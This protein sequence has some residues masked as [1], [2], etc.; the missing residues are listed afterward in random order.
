MKKLR[1]LPELF[2]VTLPERRGVC[3]RRFLMQR[4]VTGVGD[5]VVGIAAVAIDATPARWIIGVS[6]AVTKSYRLVD[7][8][9]RLAIG[10]VDRHWMLRATHNLLPILGRRRSR[11]RK[12]QRQRRDAN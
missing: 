4:I 9:V 2:S 3:R 8:Q 7:R 11:E 1:H 6:L 5:G 10:A 12:H